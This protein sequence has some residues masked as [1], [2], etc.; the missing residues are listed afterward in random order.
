MHGHMNIR[1]KFTIRPNERLYAVFYTDPFRCWGDG[2]HESHFPAFVWGQYM[3]V[4]A[5]GNG[6]WISGR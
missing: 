6:C 5:L 4:R 2:D 3:D 1:F